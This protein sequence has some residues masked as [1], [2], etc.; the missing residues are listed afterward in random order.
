MLLSVKKPLAN[1]A[2]KFCHLIGMASM[3]LFYPIPSHSSIWK[4]CLTKIL[5]STFTE[6]TVNGDHPIGAADL[7]GIPEAQRKIL[8]KSDLNIIGTLQRG[9]VEM[10]VTEPFDYGEREGALM[11]VKQ[12]DKKVVRFIYRSNS[13]GIWRVT[14]GV[15][16][17]WL[18]KGQGEDY[19]CIAPELQSIL[20]QKIAELNKKGAKMNR[21][22]DPYGILNGQPDGFAIL[23]KH[24]V[25]QV[26]PVLSEPKI[27]PLQSTSPRTGDLLKAIQDPKDITIKDEKL[28]PNFSKGPVREYKT[29]LGLAY[30]PDEMVAMV[31]PSNDGSIEYTLFKDASNHVYFSSARPTTAKYNSFGIPEKGVD[32]GALS[33]PLWEYMQEIP[34][35]YRT[36]FTYSNPLIYANNR[37]MHYV[38]H[39]TAK[40]FEDIPGK[41][42]YWF[43][44]PYVKEI[45]EVKRWY[46]AT[47]TRMPDK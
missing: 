1:R 29:R 27:E 11:I 38:D 3:I 22:S 26:E 6:K 4:N 14:D 18:S 12:G 42:D 47:G 35:G 34:N 37:V 32:L 33:T 21:F 2:H 20:D 19:M 41:G 46:E 31:Y 39:T 16:E 44:W 30:C 13:S 40:A 28:R 10:T 17:S 25:I 43:N 24:V 5:P 7:A 8:E 45:P 36:D 15:K 23:N 9:D